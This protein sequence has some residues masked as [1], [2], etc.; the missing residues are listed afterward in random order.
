MEA[1]ARFPMYV[2]LSEKKIVIIGGG[3]IA[4]RRVGKLLPF[5]NEL[6]IISP[7]L[8]EG[9]QAICRDAARNRQACQ[10]HWEERGITDVRTLPVDADMILA[11]TNDPQVNR[12]VLEFCHAQHI[13]VN[14]CDDRAACDFHFPSIVISEDAVIGI[15]SGGQDIRRVKKIRRDIEKMDGLR[16]KITVG[17]R[18]SVLAVA[19]SNIVIRHLEAFHPELEISLL[20][21]KTKGDKILDRR[22][23]EIGGKGLFV[24]ELDQALL[25]HQTDLS[26]HSLKDLPAEIPA[27]LPLVAF[28]VRE[29]PRDVLVLPEGATE[30]DFS[31]PIGTSSQRRILQL[32]DLYPA[33][34]FQSVRG[35]LQTRLRKLDSGEYG[36]LILA[37]AGLKRLGL[38]HRICR[39]FAVDEVIPSAGQGIIA[40]QGRRGEAYDF[41]QSFHDPETELSAK[42]E[43]AY[44]HALGAGCSSPVAVHATIQEGQMT[45]RGFYYDEERGQSRKN[46]VYGPATDGEKLAEQL[47][48]MVRSHA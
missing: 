17:S 9:L 14:V 25:A 5:C 23:D 43:R 40:V 36:A 45:L 33:A 1:K 39:Y 44:I 19:Q 3:K 24:K 47:A 41:L 48:E 20:T 46:E 12:G 27:E 37:A 22:L 6:T 29:D 11:C 8:S 7:V 32:R 30:I 42:A 38:A 18:E 16:R 28:S 2:D 35:N 34:D 31:K 21:M 10:I 15:S 13:L 26:V 4:E